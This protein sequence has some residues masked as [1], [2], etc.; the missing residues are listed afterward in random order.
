MVGMADPPTPD[1]R[2][3]EPGVGDGVFIRALLESGFPKPAGFDIDEENARRVA[4]RHKG[5]AEIKASD[6]LQVPAQGSYDLVIGNPP[7]VSWGNLAQEQRKHLSQDPFWKPLSNGQWDL[8][9]AFIIWS[10]EHLR[11]GGQLIFIVPY[12]W[13]HS[14][15]A[16]GLRNYLTEQGQMERIIHFGEYKLFS[17]C[18]PNCIIFSWRKRE[19]GMV[20]REIEVADYQGENR[21]VQ[22]VLDELQHLRGGGQPGNK[23]WRSWRQLQFADGEPW[24]LADPARIKAAAELEHACAGAKLSDV[25][26]VAVGMV[27]GCDQAFR[28]A[29]EQID[30]W[31]AK[32]R[33]AVRQMVK[34]KHCQPYRLIGTQPMIIADAIKSERELAEYPSL[35][36]HLSAHRDALEGRYLSK[37]TQWWHWATPRNREKVEKSKRGVLFIPGIDRSRVL[38]VALADESTDLSCGGDALAMVPLKET[39]ESDH[40]LLAWMNSTHVCSW[41]QAKGSKTGARY[42]Y[43]QAYMQRVPVRRIDF[44]DPREADLHRQISKLA[45]QA[46]AG[47]VDEDSARKNLDALFAELLG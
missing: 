27:S 15:Y 28:L 47:T 43:T 18:Y 44:S 41:Y 5:R 34:A 13:F 31:D 46:T 30:D 26:T 45:R 9:Y 35:H 16:S 7:Y 8:L 29:D 12:N 21:P 39:A 6:F 23:D 42:R 10:G 40:Y 2:S 22:E 19:T 32:S 33:K 3:L 14:T 25:C 17:D 38:R 4:Q 36:A 11:P 24:F 1:T 37:G 20:A